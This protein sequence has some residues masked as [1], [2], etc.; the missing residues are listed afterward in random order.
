MET[1]FSKQIP[2]TIS[3]EAQ[4]ILQKLMDDFD[5]DTKY[6][7][8]GNFTEWKALQLA[9]E[10]AKIPLNEKTVEA[11]GAKVEDK[12]FDKINYLEIHPK[13]YPQ[14]EK[15]IIYLHGGG[16]TFYSAKTSLT[17]AVPLA[18]KSGKK[19]LA[20]DYPLAPIADFQTITQCFTDFYG[21]LLLTGTNPKN[22]AIYGDS[23]GGGLAAGGLL[24][25]K[26][27]GFPMPASLVLWSPWT[28]LSAIGDSYLSMVN[29][30]PKLQL[31]N[32]LIPCAMAY[33]PQSEH[34]NPYV[35]PVYGK[36]DSN[37][38]PTMIQIGTRE[39]FLSDAV[40]LFQKMDEQQ[41]VSVILDP[42]EGMWHAW[43]KEYTL[44]EAKKA[45][46]KTCDFMEKYWK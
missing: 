1:N 26:D 12:K 33:A 6:P 20:L 22:I 18:D 27:D 7:E 32:R 15:V 14:S 41:G 39:I 11:F 5:P 21:Q 30:D 23:A 24:K 29:Y 34:Q 16:Y 45:I 44:P 19:V 25:L 10:I 40:R 36:Y 28:D 3:P 46:E 13:N 42:Y 8:P 38:P 43:Q 31:K 2:E 4:K 35:S 9:A 17:G 37:F